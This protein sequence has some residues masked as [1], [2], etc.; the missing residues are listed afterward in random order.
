[1]LAAAFP[2]SNIGGSDDAVRAYVIAT[3]DVSLEAI[4]AGVKRFLKGKVPGHNPNF[5]PSAAAL[6]AECD[7]QERA[8]K[9]KAHLASIPQR[10]P[11]Q[12]IE[13]SPEHR[14]AM[15]RRLIEAKIIPPSFTVG[16]AEGDRE[17]A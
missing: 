9:A 3:E 5:A 13:Y 12:K 15:Q 6:G 7:L 10:E 16:D 11:V 8:L 14:M 1:M 2:A 17:V 4:E